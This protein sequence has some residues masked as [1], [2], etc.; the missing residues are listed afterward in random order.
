M[1]ICVLQIFASLVLAYIPMNRV[2][3]AEDR[4]LQATTADKPA[5]VFGGT[6]AQN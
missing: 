3:M 4:R 5:F 1:R 6:G 2:V